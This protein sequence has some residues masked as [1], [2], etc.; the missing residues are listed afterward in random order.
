MVAE[1]KKNFNKIQNFIFLV[2]NFCESLVLHL[3]FLLCYTWK[4]VFFYH[5]ERTL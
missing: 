1:K 2:E 5:K 4:K 3:F